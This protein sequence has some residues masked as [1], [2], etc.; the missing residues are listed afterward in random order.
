MLFYYL[1][2]SER[3]HGP[4]TPEQFGE[5]W[6]QGSVTPN[7]L[8]RT[9][10][11]QQWVP[12]TSLPDHVPGFVVAG[13]DG[14]P[15]PKKLQHWGYRYAVRLMKNPLEI[16]LWLFVASLIV[17]AYR[18]LE[19]EWIFPPN[20]A[21]APAIDLSPDGFG[22]AR[23][24]PLLYRPDGD[25]AEF[26]LVKQ[27]V[28]PGSLA[29]LVRRALSGPQHCIKPDY[30]VSL[31]PD[32]P[33]GRF[34]LKDHNNEIFFSADDPEAQLAGRF[35]PHKTAYTL[36]AVKIASATNEFR[37]ELGLP[38]ITSRTTSRADGASVPRPAPSWPAPEPRPICSSHGACRCRRKRTNC[39]CSTGWKAI[40]TTRPRR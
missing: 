31:P 19:L 37:P 23:P 2:A 3:Q 9:D 29:G 18:W 24:T 12:V 11:M 32:L 38:R 39:V 13:I 8:A 40:R 33:R 25:G 6:R 21:P 15:E 30:I 7:T 20:K 16:L 17:A 10:R 14:G 27:R 36:S 26:T 34:Y 35:T 4:F 1:D 5:L 22:G 28:S